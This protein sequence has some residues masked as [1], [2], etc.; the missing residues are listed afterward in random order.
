MSN[1]TLLIALLMLAPMAAATFQP[2]E[3]TWTEEL[4]PDLTGTVWS[5]EGPE[6]DD[7][8][9]CYA[10]PAATEPFAAAKFMRSLPGGVIQDQ[11]LL[12]SKPWTTNTIT[13]VR[14]CEV[15]YDGDRAAVALAASSGSNGFFYPY[16][17]GSGWPDV[18][19]RW[20]VCMEAFPTFTVQDDS[21]DG[22]CVAPG[23]LDSIKLDLKPNG[24]VGMLILG[25][26]SSGGG[27]NPGGLGFCLFDE[28]TGIETCTAIASNLRI[29]GGAYP[30]SIEAGPHSIS[31]L[32]FL[33]NGDWLATG[34]AHEPGVGDDLFIKSWKSTDDGAT[35]VETHEFNAWSV[36]DALDGYSSLIRPM[37][38]SMLDADVGWMTYADEGFVVWAC[39]T[40][41][42]GESWGCSS[43]VD[44]GVEPLT[45]ALDLLPLSF[46]EAWVVSNGPSESGGFLNTEVRRIKVDAGGVT[47]QSALTGFQ[48]AEQAGV[49]IAHSDGGN[50]LIG[51]AARVVRGDLGGLGEGDAVAT[52][53]G[54]GLV[55]FADSIGFGGDKGNF[56]FGLILVVIS[57]GVIGFV[58]H[59]MAGSKAAGTGAAIGAIAMSIGN[60]VLGL[61]GPVVMVLFVVAAGGF[62]TK[63]VIGLT[64]GG[65]AA[66]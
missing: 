66:E 48:T 46:S 54:E 26:W 41:D 55:A 58:M 27:A 53:L 36:T 56:L 30:G 63:F 50:A 39:R 12:I 49:F 37:E 5:G 23:G 10:E 19:D 52:D 57:M 29:D 65:A 33:G 3:V 6:H 24:D 2:S 21:V 47:T 43:V 15:A 60:T 18:A 61:W 16:Q 9:L 64:S 20:R 17:D 59:G 28:S 11:G 32:Q 45:S 13:P 35:W 31:G 40:A 22:A 62:V 34:Y 42:G 25:E 14:G 7:W 44:L 4:L 8:M 1:K 51:N 38:L